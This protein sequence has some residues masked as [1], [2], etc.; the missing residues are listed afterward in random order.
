M[1]KRSDIYVQW[2]DLEDDSLNY[3]GRGPIVDLIPPDGGCL[4]ASHWPQRTADFGL[5]LITNPLNLKP[6]SC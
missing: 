2:G 3:Y 1:D 5:T 4:K 6:Q